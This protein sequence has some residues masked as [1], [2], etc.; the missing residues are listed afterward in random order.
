MSAAAARNDLAGLYMA[1]G[2]KDFLWH[3]EDQ[4]Q[5]ALKIT[6][7]NYGRD[8]PKVANQLN[9]LALIYQKLGMISVFM[10]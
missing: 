1:E 6:E 5:W 10:D 8:H 9:N 3:G 2:G 7:K 4:C